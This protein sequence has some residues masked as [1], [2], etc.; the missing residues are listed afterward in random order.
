ML[1]DL[2]YQYGKVSKQRTWAGHD[3]DQL[4]WV[5]QLKL[6]IEKCLN[7][8]L[9]QAMI[10]AVSLGHAAQVTDRER[11]SFNVFVNQ[12]TRAKLNLLL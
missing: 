6:Q 8:G 7:R 2:L 5:M 9:E 12:V 4:V 3:L 1:T 11:S 10:L